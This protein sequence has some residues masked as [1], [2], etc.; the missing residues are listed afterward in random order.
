AHTL[1][2]SDDSRRCRRN[3]VLLENWFPQAIYNLLYEE[4]RTLVP[5]KITLVGCDIFRFTLLRSVDLL[6]Y[7]DTETGTKP[8]ADAE[9]PNTVCCVSYRRLSKPEHKY[10]CDLFGCLCVL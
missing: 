7:V 1:G 2:K 3:L 4:S 8:F 5:T 9:P 6:H 10:P